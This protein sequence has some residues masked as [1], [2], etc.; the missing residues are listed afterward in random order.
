VSSTRRVRVT[1]R[2]LREDLGHD[3]PS[4]EVDLG[5]L[6]HPLLDEARRVAPTA[7]T[8]QKRILSIPHPLVFRLRHGRWRGATWTEEAAGRF[9]LLAGSLREAGSA[10]DAFEVFK[11]LYDHGRLLPA[12]DDELRDRA[13][14]VARILQA[15]RRRVPEWVERLPIGTDATLELG[16]EVVVRAHCSATDEVWVAIPTRTAS[17]ADLNE[18][19]R[20]LL[21]AIFEQAIGPAASEPR[22]DW[23]SGPLAWYEAARFYVR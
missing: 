10:D 13:E 16:G 7:P 8:G 14:F 22:P 19:L 23:P 3:L 21:F 9:W 4:L 18:R 5:T 6:E 11:D 1:L 12:Q 17:G 15:A 2:C 20:A